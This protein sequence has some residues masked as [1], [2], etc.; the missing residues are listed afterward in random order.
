[1]EAWGDS[2]V[3]VWDELTIR[4]IQLLTAEEKQKAASL[5][6]VNS[7]PAYRVVIFGYFHRVVL[8]LLTLRIFV[9]LV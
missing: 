7:L 3:K 4:I 5:K 1:M 6:K 9:T 8:F 2:P